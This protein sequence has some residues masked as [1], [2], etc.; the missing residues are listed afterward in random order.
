MTT[1]ER[2]K[3]RVDRK[4]I[5]RR[6]QIVARKLKKQGRRSAWILGASPALVTRMYLADSRTWRKL[7]ERYG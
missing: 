3:A 6:R 4:E 7:A 5:E 1:K 2:E